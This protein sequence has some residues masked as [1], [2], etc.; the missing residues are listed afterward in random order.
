LSEL[1]KTGRIVDLI[2]G[3]IALE[4][5]VLL[6]YARGTARGIAPMALL[7]NLAAGAC[8]LLALRFAL[9][10]APWGWMAVCLAAGLLAHVADLAQRWR[11]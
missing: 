2:I 11:R 7:P 10:A 1:F 5:V 4:A 6:M 3:L 9:V 8:L